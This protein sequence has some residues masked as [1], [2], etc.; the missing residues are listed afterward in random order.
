MKLTILFLHFAIVNGYSSFGRIKYNNNPTIFTRDEMSLPT[1]ALDIGCGNGFSTNQLADRLPT[2][3]VI[4]LD[5]NQKS[6][7]FA[8]KFYPYLKFVIGRAEDQI[9]PKSVFDHVQIQFSMLDLENK[10]DVFHQIKRILKPDGNLYLID[11]DQTQEYMS[12]MRKKGVMSYFYDDDY[13]SLITKFF[14]HKT[15]EVYDGIVY[16][17]YSNMKKIIQSRDNAL[18][19]SSKTI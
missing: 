10:Y 8:K 2:T 11:Y 5:K 15:T 6:I 3:Y 17:H 1:Y 19:D 7:D 14:K 4:G 16:S 12:L 9:F 18:E 13:K